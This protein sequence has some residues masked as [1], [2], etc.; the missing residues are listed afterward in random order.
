MLFLSSKCAIAKP[1]RQ[2]VTNNSTEE[3]RVV[4]ETTA[5]GDSQGLPSGSGAGGGG[6]ATATRGPDTP[7]A[8]QR[9]LR[10]G[11]SDV[12]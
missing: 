8:W 2:S 10:Q 6:S 9:P 5:I 3:S 1:T 7:R 12:R 11:I 4:T